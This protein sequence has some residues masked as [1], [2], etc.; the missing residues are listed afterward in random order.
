MPPTPRWRRV[1]G[2]LTRFVRATFAV[3]TA[4]SVPGVGP[5]ESQLVTGVVVMNA[6]R[7]RGHTAMCGRVVKL[8]FVVAVIV[9]SRLTSCTCTS[10]KSSTNHLQKLR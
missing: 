3:C 5:A 6:V 7:R 10:C 2:S 4:A 1:G 8:I 9:L